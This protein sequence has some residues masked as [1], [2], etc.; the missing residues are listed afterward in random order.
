R[1]DLSGL[2][3]RPRR[4]PATAPPPSRRRRGVCRMRPATP[5]ITRVTAAMP[6]VPPALPEA[7][8]PAL[9]VM[10]E[11]EA[12]ADGERFY[13]D[14]DALDWRM[15]DPVAWAEKHVIGSMSR[16]WPAVARAD[17]AI[18]GLL[19]DALRA[20]AVQPRAFPRWW[21]SLAVVLTNGHPERLRANCE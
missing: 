7:V 21:L 2:G 8:P 13:K 9:R 3:S 19:S 4:D 17:E 14:M 6:K 15:P 1:R 5:L 18:G 12:R 16:R 20:V 10:L 11:P